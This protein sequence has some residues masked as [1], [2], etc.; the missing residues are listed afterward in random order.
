MRGESPIEKVVVP[1]AVTP[2]SPRFTPHP[3]SLRSATFSLKG[4]RKSLTL[5]PEIIVALAEKH[6]ALSTP[7]D[8]K[9][10]VFPAPRNP[11]V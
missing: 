7:C 9:T 1:P 6:P 8:F 4:R 3:P 5:P 2:D 10:R 11:P